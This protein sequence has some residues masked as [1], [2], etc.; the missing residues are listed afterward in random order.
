MNLLDPTYIR[1][2]VDYSFGDQ[3]GVFLT[4]GY[5]KDAN[6][7]NHEFLNKVGQFKSVGNKIMTLFIDNIRLYYRENAKFTA[8]ELNNLS[9]R[10]FKISKINEFRNQDLLNLCSSIQGINFIIFTGFEDTPIDEEIFNRIPENVLGIYASNATTFGGKVHPIPYGIQRKLSER[11]NRHNIILKLLNEDYEPKKKLYINHSLGTNPK[12][13]LINDFFSNDNWV[14][15]S[16]PL[17][18]GEPSYETYLKDIKNHKFMICPDGNAIGCECH[19]DWEV[20]Y[21]RRVPVLERSQY[22][23][24]IFDGIPVLFVDSFFDVTEELLDNNIHL[25]EKMKN[26]DMSHLDISVLYKKILDN[27]DIDKT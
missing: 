24:K 3:S 16:S 15:I 11:D 17:D 26:F 1:D 6:T 7:Q 18:I 4:N 20:L 9:A 27:Y 19:R 25:F 21:M 13:A 2:R 12:R 22:L 23:E 8:M 10:S 5:M 14:T